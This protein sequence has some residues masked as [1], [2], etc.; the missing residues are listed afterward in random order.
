MGL[1][2]PSYC[3]QDA[4]RP[5]MAVGPVV[6]IGIDFDDA[7]YWDGQLIG[8]RAALSA[9]MRDIGAVNWDKQV[10]VHIRPNALASYGAVVAVLAAAQRSGVRKMDVNGLSWS[11]SIDWSCIAID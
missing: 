10:E 11:S 9:K 7:F 3:G 1:D 8:S 5:L 2:D 6:H 4:Q